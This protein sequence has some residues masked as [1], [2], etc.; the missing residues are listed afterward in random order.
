MR[1][2]WAGNHVYRASALRHPKTVSDVQEVISATRNIRVLG[3][4]HSFNDIADTNGIQLSLADLA[5][6]ISID[7]DRHRVIV[8]GGIRYGELAPVLHQSGW[9]LANLASLPHITVAGAVVTATHGSGSSIGNLATAVAAMDIVTA[10]GDVATLSRDADA[11]IFNGAV[12]NLGAIGA[13]VSLTLDIERSYQVSQNVYTGL[14]LEVLANEFEAIF[15]AGTSV[16]VFTD[17]C[18]D[19]AQAVWVKDRLR[20][21]RT[22]AFPGAELFGAPMASQPMHPLPGGP[23]ENCT[24]QMGVAGPWHE[25]LPHFRLDFTPSKGEEIQAEFFMPREEARGAVAVKRQHGERLAPMLLASEVRTVAADSLWLSP[26]RGQ[27]YFGIHFTFRRNWEALQAVLPQLEADLGRLGAVP[28]WAKVTTMAP[29][30][31]AAR[32]PRLAD[33]RE[34]VKAYDPAGKFRNDLVDRIVFGGG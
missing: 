5:R 19:L 14:S 26:S 31:I 1:T 3:A 10:I 34:L 29:G 17:W 24:E 28:H 33:F 4:R 2:N 18:G 21:P 13:I 27:P 7:H 23:A 11:E 25:R 15:A 8:D 9:A 12:V 32:M 6:V 30:V 22:T 20:E 16:S